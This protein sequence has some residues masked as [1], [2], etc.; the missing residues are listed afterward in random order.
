MVNIQLAKNLRHLRK[1][2]KQKQ[3]DIAEIFSISRQAVSNYE[4]MYREPDLELLV[5]ISTYYKLNLDQLIL[6]DLANPSSTATI[7][8]SHNLAIQNSEER[9][10]YLTDEEVEL[11]LNFRALSDSERA[12]VSG[13]AKKK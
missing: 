8:I 9:S 6:H 1:L 5:R 12:L 2:N 7:D 13:F 3:D 4:N 11:I 10:I